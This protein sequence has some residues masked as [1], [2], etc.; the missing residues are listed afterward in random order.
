MSFK[1]WHV[2][3]EDIL[4]AL[5]RI[6]RYTEDMSEKA[7]CA[8]NRSVDAVVRNLEIIGEAARRMPAEVVQ[9]H[10]QIPWS[11]MAEMRHILVH[12][13]HSVDSGIVWATAKHDLPPLREPLR[14]ILREPAA[15]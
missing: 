7:F 2:R 12:E 10:P 11:H 4:E 14:A 5:D 15:P 9:R 6:E 13:Y 1:D 8:D 3:V